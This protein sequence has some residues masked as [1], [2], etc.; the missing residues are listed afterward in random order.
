[1]AETGKDKKAKEQLSCSAALQDFIIDAVNTKFR[2]YNRPL[3]LAI[4]VGMLTV[5]A[6]VLIGFHLGKKCDDLSEYVPEIELIGKTSIY[7]EWT[8]AHAGFDCL[9]FAKV[10]P[11]GAIQQAQDASH[12][13]E[14]PLEEHFCVPGTGG[15][16]NFCSKGVPKYMLKGYAELGMKE[17][18]LT[19]PRHQ[20]SSCEDLAQ[21]AHRLLQ[22][23]LGAY[24]FYR[25]CPDPLAS[26]GAAAGYA[27]VV[28]LAL[29]IIIV[30]ILVKC[31][32]LKGKDDSLMKVWIAE[33]SKKENMKQ[34]QLAQTFGSQSA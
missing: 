4:I 21:E 22:K 29:T 19:A 20:G 11:Q 34:L 17:G 7:E 12:T 27:G 5:A 13:H 8:E 18:E 28:E 24:V 9:Y 32:C 30:F 31:K 25:T 2:F 1:M 26:F 14:V 3:T 16:A 6:V 15:T 23:S 33:I 10:D